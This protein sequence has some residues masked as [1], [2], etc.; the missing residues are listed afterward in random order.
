MWRESAMNEKKVKKWR[1]FFKEDRTLG[2]NTQPHE[3]A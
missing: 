1:R 2:V 3:H